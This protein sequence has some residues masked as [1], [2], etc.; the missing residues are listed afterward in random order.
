MALYYLKRYSPFIFNM[1]KTFLWFFPSV[2]I[3]LLLWFFIAWHTFLDTPI[4]PASSP[5]LDYSLEPGSSIKTLASDL[6]RQKRLSHP[7]FLI[8]LAYQKGLTK[9]L[10][11]GEYIFPAGIKPLAL[12]QQ[13]V[14]GDVSYHRFTL[15]EG[16]TFKQLMNALNKD[17][18]LVHSLAKLNI[19]QIMDRL[20]LPAQNPEGLFFPA[21]YH[22]MKGATDLSILKMAHRAMN[23][24]L[25]KTWNQRS[26]N[27][28]YETPYESLIAA[29]LIEKE[30]AQKSERPIIAGVIVRR[31]EKNMPLQIDASVI[32]GLGNAYTG[33]LGIADLRKNTAYNTY[34]V[35]GLPPTPIAMPGLASI[36]AALHPDNT[37]IIYYVSKGNGTHQFS[38]TLNEQNKAVKTYQIDM[39]Y[40]KIGLRNPK[41]V[42]EKIWYLTDLVQKFLGCS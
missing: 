28:P 35:H 23:D 21:T 31:L 34:T 15:I 8:L 7:T 38:T 25:L 13:I 6:Y 40:P 29:S 12:L 5:P 18:G 32:Y 20:N 1:R 4:I 41:I 36:E 9:K 19:S 11:A 27:L 24:V 2:I 42:C 26:L 14:A 39:R 3:I 16:W 30:T 37:L 33:K 22:Y 17:P 10:Q